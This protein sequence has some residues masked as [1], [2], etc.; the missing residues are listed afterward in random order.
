MKRLFRRPGGGRP[1]RGADWMVRTQLEAR[2]LRDP[3]VLNAMRS[4]PRERF[5]PEYLA[6][7]AYDD[8]ALPI[9]QS[10]TISQPYI[11]ALMTE[12]L[13]LPA[14]RATHPGEPLKALDV[15]TGSGYQ[16]AVLAAM[17]AKV[18]SI[19]RHEAL[20]RQAE[21]RLAQLGYDVHVVV[22]DGSAGAPEEAPFAGIVV[23]A[24]SPEIPRPLVDQLADGGRLVVPVGSRFEQRIMLV[25]KQGPEVT[26]SPLEPAVFVPLLGEHGFPER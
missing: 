20:A 16:A 25:A 6:A 22:G 5:V 8:N 26:T 19:E 23:G 18:V 12:A 24:A 11:V 17:G 7:H 10:Q 3:E 2:G 15:G 4:V 1:E 14:W 13:A 9:G 21:E